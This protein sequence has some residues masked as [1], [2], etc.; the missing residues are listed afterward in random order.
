MFDKIVIKFCNKNDI[1]VEAYSTLGTA[2]SA[3]KDEP[4]ARQ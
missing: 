3:R 4:I 2:D 1:I